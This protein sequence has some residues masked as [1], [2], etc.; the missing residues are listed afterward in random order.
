MQGGD[1]GRPRFGI[2]R[3]LTTGR[4]LCGEPGGVR[5]SCLPAQRL[6]QAMGSDLAEAALGKGPAWLSPGLLE[7]TCD[8]V[9]RGGSVH[10]PWSRQLRAA[11][12]PLVLTSHPT[13][14]R[15]HGGSSCC[16]P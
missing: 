11:G 15:A 1:A 6:Q 3:A 4:S 12:A 9:S 8:T 5:T 10:S 7:V 16:S 2:L 13:A 14:G